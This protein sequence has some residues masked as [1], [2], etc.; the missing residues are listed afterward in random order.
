M[1]PM[2]ILAIIL[3]MFALLRI[4]YLHGVYVT[5]KKLYK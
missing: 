2:V 1:E 3:I 5:E 4:G